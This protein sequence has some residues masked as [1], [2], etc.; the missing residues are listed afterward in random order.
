VTTKQR[1]KKH[2]KGFMKL[3]DGFVS[4]PYGIGGRRLVP[5]SQTVKTPAAAAKQR[6]ERYAERAPQMGK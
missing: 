2:G 4:V 1:G 6:V 3:G 5:D